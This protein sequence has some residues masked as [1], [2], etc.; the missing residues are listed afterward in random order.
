ML[1]RIYLCDTTKP[2]QT[3][4]KTMIVKP[5]RSIHNSRVIEVQDYVYGFSTTY[6]LKYEDGRKERIKYLDTS[7]D[8]DL[9]NHTK[10]EIKQ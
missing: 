7:I 3:Q 4:D 6:I 8:E 5:F 2:N 9:N 1:H 10:Q